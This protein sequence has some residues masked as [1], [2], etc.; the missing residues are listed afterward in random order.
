MPAEIVIQ[1]REELIYLL[2]EA[3]EFEHTV[4][5]SYLYAQWT[6]KRGLDEGVTPTELAAIE[7]WRR[8]LG[9]VALEEM[10]HL[11]LVNNVDSMVRFLDDVNHPA[12][13][14]NIDV[15]HLLL[16]KVAPEELRPT[17]AAQRSLALALVTLMNG[18]DITALM[19]RTVNDYRQTV[20]SLHALWNLI[21][22]RRI[23]RWQPARRADASGE[24]GA[25]Q[26]DAPT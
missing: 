11:S 25:S 14:A 13:Q 9:Q 19:A 6:L 5:C 18:L 7:R 10:L 26:L 23:D 3:A 22:G 2:C 15:S 24:P 1:D 16:A 17:P 21:S 4:M 8:S 12:V 20:A